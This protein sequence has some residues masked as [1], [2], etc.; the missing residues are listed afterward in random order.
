MLTAPLLLAVAGWLTF[1]RLQGLVNGNPD[2][3]IPVFVS[4]WK[5]TPMYWEQDRYGMLLPFLARPLHHPLT[6]LLAQQFAAALL[7]ATAFITVPWYLLG[8]DR[9]RTAGWVALGICVA[10]TP[11]LIQYDAF[12]LAQPYGVAHGLAALGLVGLTE[13]RAAR[14]PWWGGAAA[15]VFLPLAMWV[16]AAIAPVVLALFLGRQW[17]VQ[18]HFDAGKLVRQPEIALVGLATAVG[19][20]IEHVLGHHSGFQQKY[21]RTPA[22]QWPAGWVAMARHAADAYGP[23]LFLSLGIVAGIGLV[24]SIT[25]TPRRDPGPVRAALTCLGAGVALL[26]AFG[27]LQHVQNNGYAARY[28]LTPMFLLIVATG[29]LVSSVLGRATRIAAPALLLLGLV[30][31]HGVPTPGTPRALIC[32]PPVTTRAEAVLHLGAT[33]V[34]GSY[35]HTWPL[36]F[37]ANLLSVERGGTAPIWGLS[38][39]SVPI[40]PLWRARPLREWRIA[41]VTGDPQLPYWRSFY[42]LPRLVRVAQEGDVNL[43]RVADRP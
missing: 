40:T 33:H 4:L 30:C 43:W 38:G 17:I 35:W 10:G 11:L 5:W 22:A 3:L 34:L 7:S 2:S 14:R 1:G 15:F 39:R 20:R 31:R 32:V 16:N 29:I 18:K 37:Q 23:V 28:A 26:L 21:L 41:T 42:K 13:L 27:T 6:N 8:G 24:W 9:G 19:L 12:G 36:V 25:R